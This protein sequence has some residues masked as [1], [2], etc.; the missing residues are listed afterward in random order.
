M[1]VTLDRFEAA[2]DPRVYLFSALARRAA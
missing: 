2:L 1:L